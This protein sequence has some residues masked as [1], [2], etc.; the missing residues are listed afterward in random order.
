MPSVGSEQG[1]EKAG[2]P[3]WVARGW[4]QARA[5]WAQIPPPMRPFLVVSMGI[6][7][8]GLVLFLF[9]LVLLLRAAR[10]AV[11]RTPSSTTEGVTFPIP[12][13]LHVKGTVL[14]VRPLAVQ[15]GSWPVSRGQRGVVYWMEGTFTNWVFGLP[16]LPEN[17]RLVE[18]LQEGDAIEV[19]MNTGPALGFEVVGKQQ[20]Q[21][22]DTSLLA[23][24][25]PG[26]T[27]LLVGGEP[28]W[29]VIASPRLELPASPLETGRV[30][31]GV[32]LQVGPVRLVV[33]GVEPRW[34]GPGI[35]ADFVGV[36]L[37][38]E[39]TL[40]GAEPLAVERMEM[41]LVDAAGRR[42]QPT[43]LEGV[44]LPSGR[45]APG[46]ALQERIAFLI[47]RNSAEG[48]LGWRFNPLPGQAAAAEVEFEL[49]PPTPTPAPEGL[50]RVQIQSVE[51]LPGE[52][53]LVIQGGIGN[54]G[55]QLILLEET[56]VAL[57]GPDGE[58]VPLLE[59]SPA[60]PW[61][62]PAG[63]NLAFELRFAMAAP[64]PSVLQIGAQRFQIR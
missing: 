29:A 2:K 7:A 32:P 38:V 20:I 8:A 5:R 26:F 44:P 43:A 9:G 55:D 51:W 14:T 54:P 56:E 35:P 30:P 24:H 16:D 61:Q 15:G 22:E 1:P 28:R 34:S 18:G 60:W 31:I 39:M 27:L 19:E 4:A 63:R 3:S 11:P 50:L 37:D 23:Q 52:R 41:R 48:I 21:P 58:R 45:L 57:T 33:R 59:A 36:V 13:R 46:G 49:P 47:P 25:R 62:I 17:R 53:A 42:Y 40:T 10:P 64:G 6:G 12:L